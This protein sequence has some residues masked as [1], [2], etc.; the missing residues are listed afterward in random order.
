MR[1]GV[2]E[3]ESK[4]RERKRLCVKRSIN[5]VGDI[6]VWRSGWFFVIFLRRQ[7]ISLSFRTTRGRLPE[8]A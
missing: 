6:N 5:G 4:G 2:F 8:S 7:S 3:E 1:G